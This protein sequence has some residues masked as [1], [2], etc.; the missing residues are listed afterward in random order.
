MFANWVW[1][2]FAVA[3][4]IYWRFTRPDMERPMKI[5]LIIP[6]FFI[7][8]CLVLLVFSIYS[9]PM[10]CL[11]GFGISLIGIPVYY[12]FLYYADKH[13]ETFKDLMGK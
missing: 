12:V 3:G 7:A 4:L 13:P 5:H 2:A 8:L 10:E 6:F 11:A 1:Y 9:Q